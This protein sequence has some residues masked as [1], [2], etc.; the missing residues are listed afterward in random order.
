MPVNRQSAQEED[1][2]TVEE[3]RYP[4]RIISGNIQ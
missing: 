1:E 2:K 3:A 4:P